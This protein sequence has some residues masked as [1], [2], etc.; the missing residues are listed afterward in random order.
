MDIDSKFVAEPE[1]EGDLVGVS[2][3]AFYF[4]IREI[5][6]ETN[7]LSTF[8]NYKFKQYYGGGFFGGKKEEF[9]KLSRWCQSGIDKDMAN[10][11]IPRHN[12]ETAMNAYFSIHEPTLKLTPD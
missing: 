2:H 7:K 12:D 3:C 6:Q 4:N 5:P 9:F 10:K 11:I 1:I 8:Y